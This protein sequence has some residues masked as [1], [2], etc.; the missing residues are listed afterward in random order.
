MKVGSGSPSSLSR[1]VLDHQL[2]SEMSRSVYWFPSARPPQLH[3][4]FW[5]STADIFNRTLTSGDASIYQPQ[6][7][8]DL[9]DWEQI[10]M[11]K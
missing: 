4:N 2:A 3:G 1:V 6:S 5:N 7:S 11:L 10:L 9:L 8:A